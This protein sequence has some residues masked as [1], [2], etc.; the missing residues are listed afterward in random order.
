MKAREIGRKILKWGDRVFERG[1]GNI[2]S[3]KPPQLG[4]AAG[5]SGGRIG[6]PPIDSRRIPEATIK[7]PAAAPLQ[8]TGSSGE[9]APPSY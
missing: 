1:F 6:V 4:W 8:T 3:G 5:S 7:N 2:N 9:M